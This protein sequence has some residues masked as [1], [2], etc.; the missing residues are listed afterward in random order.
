M[1]TIGQ[2]VETA[3][4]A[5]GIPVISVRTG[6][7]GTDR[8]Q[9]TVQFDPSATPTQIANAQSILNTVAIDAVTLQDIDSSETIDDKKLTAVARAL[10]ECIPAPTKTLPQ[11][12]ARAIAILKTL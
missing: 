9:W 11:L 6:T 2:L 7:P 4:K 1:A 5:A 8:A 12:R 10:W 3:L